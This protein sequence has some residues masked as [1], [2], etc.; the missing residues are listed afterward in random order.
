MS[1]LSFV[2]YFFLLNQL[3][4]GDI[5]TSYSYVCWV[6]VILRDT[7]STSGGGVPVPSRAS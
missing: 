2:R 6:V 7:F 3:R 4:T 1:I 5:F